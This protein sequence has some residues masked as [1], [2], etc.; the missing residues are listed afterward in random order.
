MLYRLNSDLTKL[1]AHPFVDFQQHAKLEKDLENLLATHLETLFEDQPLLPF[2]QERRLQAEADIYALDEHGN[3]VVFELKRSMA[4]GDA[5]DQLLR[6]TQDAGR[7]EYEDIENKL[8]SYASDEYGSMSLAEAHQQAVGLTAPLRREQFN[9]EQ[10]MIV[11]GSA[12]DHSLIRGVDFWRK[13]GLDIDFI[14]YRIYEIGGERFFEFFSR[15]YDVH[16]NPCSAKGVLFD[17]CGRYY[18]N[19][20]KHMIEKKRVSA[21]GDMQDAVRIFQRGDLVFYSHRGVGLIAAAKVVGKAPHA[22]EMDGEE[23]LYWDVEFQTEL[24]KQ[25]D[26]F[27]NA[28][29]FAQV[30]EVTGHNFWWAKTAKV[31]YLNREESEHLLKE[32]QRV[33]AGK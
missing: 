26:Y 30:R 31:P 6:Y 18:P 1:D 24:P 22:D 7:W 14:P 10:R 4:S 16:T 27:P 9:R 25:F 33:L 32:L 8:R 28:M 11:V 15:P 2:H 21:F 23:E 13:K 5:L 29:P 20:A 17:T 12:A 19:A 3:V